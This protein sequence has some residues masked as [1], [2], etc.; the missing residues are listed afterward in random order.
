MARQ[1]TSLDLTKMEGV[2]DVEVCLTLMYSF[3]QVVGL[4]YC[5]GGDRPVFLFSDG[6]PFTNTVK[7]HINAFRA[8]YG[9]TEPQKDRLD[10]RHFTHSLMNTLKGEFGITITP[11][12]RQHP[13]GRD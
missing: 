3:E 10:H 11:T 4:R 8:I 5:A 6:E 12:I 9:C 2:P 1:M 13:H 7:Q